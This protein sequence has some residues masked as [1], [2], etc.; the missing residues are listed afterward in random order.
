M[1]ARITRLKLD[2]ILSY[3]L[4]R[5]ERKK[6]REGEFPQHKSHPDVRVMRAIENG[7]N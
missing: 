1:V 4:G 3:P 2:Y 6:G 5:G 7:C